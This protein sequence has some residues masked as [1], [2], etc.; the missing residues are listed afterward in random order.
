MARNIRDYDL[1]NPTKVIGV[2]K[3]TPMPVEERGDG[4]PHCGCLELQ[5]VTVTVEM[6]MLR[7]GR[8]IGTYVGCPACPYASPMVTR[9]STPAEGT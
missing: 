4:C 1:P 2:P 9:A 3:A 7:G 8:G 6:P 5:F